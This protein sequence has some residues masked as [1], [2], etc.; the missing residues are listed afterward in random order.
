M[1]SRIFQAF[2]SACSCCDPFSSKRRN[3]GSESTLGPLE[4]FVI[5]IGIARILVF[6]LVFL[7]IVALVLQ[8][9]GVDHCGE[10]RCRNSGLVAF[11]VALSVSCDAKG[12]E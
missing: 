7:L 12:L 9:P 4:S 10:Q 1:F 3:R 6:V 5:P 8:P 11:L 2:F